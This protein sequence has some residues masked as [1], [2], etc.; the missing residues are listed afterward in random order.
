MSG[1]I[2]SMRDVPRVDLTDPDVEPTDEEL[3]ALMLSVQ[4]DVCARKQ[5]VRSAFQRRVDRA[6]QGRAGGSAATADNYALAR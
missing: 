3:H 6:V 5:R 2:V 1:K 4:D